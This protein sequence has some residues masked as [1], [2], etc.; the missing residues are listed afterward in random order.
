VNTL[1]PFEL[2]KEAHITHF[3]GFLP[4]SVTPQATS[5]ATAAELDAI[6][7]DPA[8]DIRGDAVAPVRTEWV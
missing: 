8:G 6:V 7:G 5:E 2:K 3:C 1:Q 4:S